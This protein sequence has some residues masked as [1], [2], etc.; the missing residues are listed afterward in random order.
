MTDEQLPKYSRG[1]V[2]LLE[3]MRRTPAGWTS[4]DFERLYTGFGFVR[5]NRG[6]H[7]VYQYLSYPWL[8][9]AVPRHRALKAWVARDAVRLIDE[10]RQL[11]EAGHDEGH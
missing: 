6:A 7:T 8:Y 9:A 2:T 3:R 4:A 11:Q 10:L 5:R 1:A